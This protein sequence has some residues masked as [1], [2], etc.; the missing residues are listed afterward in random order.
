MKTKKLK[1]SWKNRD[2]KKKGGR[3]TENNEL[4]QTVTVAL[5]FTT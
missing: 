5:W 3:K 4:L 2:G 1:A